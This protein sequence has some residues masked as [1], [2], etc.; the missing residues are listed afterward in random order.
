MLLYGA[1]KAQNQSLPSHYGDWN[2]TTAA[3]LDKFAASLLP[4]SS[5]VSSCCK[6][7]Q[8]Q[9]HEA[10]FGDPNFYIYADLYLDSNE[11]LQELQR[12][13]KLGSSVKLK[14]E[15]FIVV[16]GSGDH[17]AQYNDDE[18]NDGMCFFFELARIH[19]DEKRIQ[20]LTSYIWDYHY[21]YLVSEFVALLANRSFD[22]AG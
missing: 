8:Y 16:N 22:A 2:K 5:L 1:I 20:Y 13:E 18:I 14:G 7:Y 9:Y 10:L 11:F 4:D 12:L 21:E 17:F 19:P 3:Y 6:H 15:Q